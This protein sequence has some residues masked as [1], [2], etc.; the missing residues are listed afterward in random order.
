M[1]FSWRL[2]NRPGKSWRL[3]GLYFAIL[4]FIVFSVLFY[5]FFDAF[6]LTFCQD[7]GSPLQILLFLELAIASVN[8]SYVP[9]ETEVQ[10]Q[11]NR[12]VV[13]HQLIEAYS[14]N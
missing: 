11:W 13:I 8:L 2:R 4:C 1:S 7:L 10:L 12:L 5:M 3:Y 14:E 9:Q 6:V